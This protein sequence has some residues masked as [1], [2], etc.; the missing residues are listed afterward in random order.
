[1]AHEEVRARLLLSVST[2]RHRACD[3]NHSKDLA[4]V[5]DAAAEPQRARSDG[6]VIPREGGGNEQHGV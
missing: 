3:I 4:F 2:T 6:D 5:D 1:M